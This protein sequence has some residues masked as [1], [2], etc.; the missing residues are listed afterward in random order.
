MDYSIGLILAVVIVAVILLMCKS[1][2]IE[3]F[4][5]ASSDYCEKAEIDN[6][7]ILFKKR[8]V[9]GDCA[10]YVLLV[11]DGEVIINE[12]CVAQISR[13]LSL[14]ESYRLKF[15]DLEVEGF[16]TKLD[17]RF[18]KGKMMLFDDD[19]LYGEF[20]MDAESSHLLE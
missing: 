12:P 6:F 3:G 11:R 18:T 15:K 9:W 5:V 20:F 4:W 19:V 7:V 10:A 17:M 13:K 2:P 1:T 16:P 14:T 8:D